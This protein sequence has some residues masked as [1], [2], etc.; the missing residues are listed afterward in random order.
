MQNDLNS[1]ANNY[2]SNDAD[3]VE[4]NTTISTSL[5]QIAIAPGSLIKSWEA[6]GKKYFNYKLDEKSLAFYSFISAKY[7]VARKVWSGID[8]EVYYIPE[9]EYNVP[10]M[11]KSIE[12]SLEYYTQ[13]FGKYHHKQCRIIE[14][15]RYSSFAQAFPGTMPYSESVGFI[16]DLRQVTNDDI[17]QVFYIVAH[18]MGHQYWAHQLCGA[19]MQGSEMMSEGFAQY[20]ALM[21]MEKEYG[22]NKM[23]KFLKYEMDGYLRGRSSEFEAERPLMYTEHQQY[24]HYQKASV[25]MYGLKEMIGENKVNEA[26]RSLLD[27]FAYRDPPYA[28]SVS[29]VR[30]FRK[31]TPD[32]LQYLINDMFERITL[33]SNRMVEAKYKKVG[34]EY[35]VNLLTNSEKFYADTLGKEVSTPISD[36]IDI[37]IFAK[38]DN[39]KNLGEPL[40]M[41]RLKLDKK[42]NKFT[43]RT[44]KL[45]YNAG[46]DPYNYLIDRIPDD[47]VKVLKE[48]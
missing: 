11:L 24:I 42:E 7:K 30:A 47:N 19:N 10:N 27:T 33:F 31:V 39:K 15:P 5:D 26:L 37:G 29:A 21:V 16:A 23:K 48:E 46:I 1:R 8:L 25:I 18:E 41:Q 4:V 12:K 36:Y 28:T 32:S 14:F 44:N 38:S 13:N 45:P 35:E 9:H 17:D 40:F 20:S 2:I 3:W 43:F 22:K 34:N 6:N